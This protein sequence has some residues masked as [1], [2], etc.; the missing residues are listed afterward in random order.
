MKK[1]GLLLLVLATAAAA[2]T[3]T[4]GSG[5]VST[6]ANVPTVRYQTP[7]SADLYC[8]GFVSKD[9]MPDA[10]FMNGG[11]QTPSTTKFTNGEVV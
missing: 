11:L 6:S 1:T 4:D 5:V 3:P 8:A 7:T 10:N 2:Q 9:R